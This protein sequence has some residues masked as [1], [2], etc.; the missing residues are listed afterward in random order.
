MMDK[1]RKSLTVRLTAIFLFP[2]LVITFFGIIYY[3]ISQR[4]AGRDASKQ[5]AY[6]LAE[7]LSFSVGAGLNDGNFDLVQTSF[8]WARGDAA[9]AFVLILDES[10]K[11]IVE[12][13]P[14]QINNDI[15]TLLRQKELNNAKDIVIGMR[16][17]EYK[18]GNWVQQLSVLLWNQS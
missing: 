13:N 17:I 3:W 12:H 1:L 7:T 4:S 18:A 9:V 2:L 14:Q 16:S 8:N 15:P 5:N 11:T 6:L 10:D